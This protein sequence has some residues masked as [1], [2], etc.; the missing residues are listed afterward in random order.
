MRK[1]NSNHGMEHDSEDELPFLS[2]DDLRR[3][4]FDI[5][6]S[7]LSDLEGRDKFSNVVNNSPVFEMG[8]D[9]RESAIDGVS[10][11]RHAQTKSNSIPIPEKRNAL[12]RGI[13]TRSAPEAQTSFSGKYPDQNQFESFQMMDSKSFVSPKSITSRED[14]GPLGLIDL[15]R[16]P[17]LPSLKNIELPDNPQIFHQ[18]HVINPPIINEADSLVVLST[19]M[20]SFSPISCDCNLDL[21]KFKV[22]ID[23]SFHTNVDNLWKILFGNV[24]STDGFIRKFWTDMGYKGIQISSWEP[25]CGESDKKESVNQNMLLEDMQVG[26][27]QKLEYIVPSTN[28]VGPKEIHTF[29][30][31]RVIG[32]EGSNSTICL[33][34]VSTTPFVTSGDCFEVHIKTCLTHDGHGVSKLRVAAQ[35][36]FIKSTWIRSNFFQTKIFSDN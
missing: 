35:V 23:H 30:K 12:N 26:Y 33:L 28:P 22:L 27:I 29:L 15:A 7:D 2:L 19:P 25:D 1:L 31:H 13:S 14:N 6:D 4:S 34:Q 32:K 10:K 36:V 3:G 24:F 18:K 9:T 11:K 20:V 8:S 5:Y 21:T 16:E 17:E